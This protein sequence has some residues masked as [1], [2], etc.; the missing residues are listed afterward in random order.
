M[1]VTKFSKYMSSSSIKRQIL[2]SI[3]CIAFSFINDWIWAMGIL[4]ASFLANTYLLVG[5]CE[6]SV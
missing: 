3:P 1:F 6:R 5:Y 4:S 2:I